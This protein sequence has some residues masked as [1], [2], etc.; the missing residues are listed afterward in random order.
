MHS[1]V[2]MLLVLQAL[3][4]LST[5]NTDMPDILQTELVAFAMTALIHCG[6]QY[7]TL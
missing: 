1:A 2:E 7:G 4:L 6:A 5:V 3:I